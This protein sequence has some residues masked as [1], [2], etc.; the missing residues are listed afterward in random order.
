MKKIYSIIISSIITTTIFSQAGTLDTTFGDGGYLTLNLPNSYDNAYPT[1][2][3]A[4]TGGG[5]F[6]II[7]YEFFLLID[8]V[9]VLHLNNDGSGEEYLEDCSNVHQN[10]YS[11][12]LQPD[13]KLLTLGQSRVYCY[14][15]D[16][17]DDESIMMRFNADYSC[18]TA[19]GNPVLSCDEPDCPSGT[20]FTAFS[21]DSLFY[22]LG[23]MVLL[24]DSK[25]LAGGYNHTYDDMMFGRLT[26]DGLPDES[27]GTD[28]LVTIEAPGD[29]SLAN[30]ISLPSGKVLLG[31]RYEAPGETESRLM[32]SK[33]NANG[34]LNTSFGA[35]G[36]AYSSFTGASGRALVATNTGSIYQAGY[37]STGTSIVLAKYNASG[38][39]DT[40]FDSDGYIYYKFEDFNTSPM[41]MVLQE[42][43]KILIAGNISKTGVRGVFVLR[44][45]ADGSIDET[46]GT[47]GY[48]TNTEEL[49]MMYGNGNAVITSDNKLMVL[50][51]N[52]YADPVIYKIILENPAPCTEPPSGL[53]ATN[54]TTNTAKLNWTA[55]EGALKYKVQ[56]RASTSPIWITVNATTN[57]KLI[58][59]L[60]A[61]TTYKYRV[62]S[63]CSATLTSA[64][65]SI[66]QFITLP[67]REG[68]NG[69]SSMVP[70]AIGIYPNP[71]SDK[72]YIEVNET[73][74]SPLTFHLYDITG[75]LIST[76]I[77]NA[78]K[79]IDVKELNAG[80]YFIE[81]TGSDL[82]TQI[83]K[84]IIE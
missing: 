50:A 7:Y 77:L 4:D 56:Y 83:Q 9:A 47:G 80:M 66:E 65:S 29:Q 20:A 31:G 74:H 14:T 70:I 24:P 19:F 54:I 76:Q 49:D 37:Y 27:F 71:A 28:G 58:T 61:N 81:F 75:K 8:Y 21:T 73:H 60:A 18:D 79:T 32:V 69:E 2:I 30:M 35:G 33:L 46:F 51:T 26:T 63:Q 84:I 59:G 62:R 48:F 39:P 82:A 16:A 15:C 53:F 72:I 10:I 38:N 3:I 45:N 13:G 64:W 23:I 55:E 12:A 34:T 40:G 42:D 22:K 67:L 11:L 25:I 17:P 44:I 57:L 41:D 78:E 52:I 6:G 36:F 68:V 5:V 1:G 43:G